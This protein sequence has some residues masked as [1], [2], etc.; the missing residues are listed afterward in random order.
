M[1]TPTLFAYPLTFRQ[2]ILGVLIYVGVAVFIFFEV[3]SGKVRYKVSGDT[4]IDRKDNPTGFWTVIGLQVIVVGILA[5][6][7]VFGAY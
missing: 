7:W 4:W 6:L 5:W 1:F 3:I 2:P